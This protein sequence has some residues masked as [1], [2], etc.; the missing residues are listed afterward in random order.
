MISPLMISPLMISPLMISPLIGSGVTLSPLYLLQTQKAP[1]W[2]LAKA[3][4]ISLVS[5]GTC[6]IQWLWKEP[7]NAW[8]A[9]MMAG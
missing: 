1:S 8:R 3:A 6:S 9:S 4:Y 2:W 7:S 5:K